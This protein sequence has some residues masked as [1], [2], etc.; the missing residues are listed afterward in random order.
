MTILISM[1]VWLLIG[2]AVGMLFG[3]VARAAAGNRT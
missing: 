3:G 1:A 2:F